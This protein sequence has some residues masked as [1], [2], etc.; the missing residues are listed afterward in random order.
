MHPK[1]LVV[2][3]AFASLQ[4]DV[5][6]GLQLANEGLAIHEEFEDVSVR[7]WLLFYKGLALSRLH[8]YAAAAAANEEAVRVALTQGQMAVTC[9]AHVNLAACAAVMGEH[10]RAKAL[11]ERALA[12]ARDV[13]DPYLIA[14][15]LYGVAQR[16]KMRGDLRDA[17]KFY[18]ESLIYTGSI[19]TQWATNVCLI[20]LADVAC[21]FGDYGRAARLLGAA[22][23]SNRIIG[24]SLIPRV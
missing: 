15:A 14:L 3:S 9:A 22:D 17:A 19:K 7:S 6:A 8:T 5:D 20:G 1:L 2:A 13:A 21:S 16:A 4:G 12:Y 18:R 10:D 11:D 24:I 23:N